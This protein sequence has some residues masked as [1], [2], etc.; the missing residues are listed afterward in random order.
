[1]HFGSLALEFGRPM[2]KR[3]LLE[4]L[5]RLGIGAALLHRHHVK[6]LVHINSKLDRS[7]AA[8]NWQRVPSCEDNSVSL[9]YCIGAG[10]LNHLPALFTCHLSAPAHRW[11]VR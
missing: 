8:I 9:R 10:E 4:T 5:W 7:S 2:Q 3:L 11:P 6:I 1:M